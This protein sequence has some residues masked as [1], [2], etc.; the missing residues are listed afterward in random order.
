VSRRYV[1][2]VPKSVGKGRV[3]MH[4]HVIHGP[5]WPTGVNEFRAWTD[6]KPPEA[7]A[8][9]PCGWAGL[10]H[11]ASEGHVQAYRDNPER[12]KR[13]VKQLEKKH[14]VAWEEKDLSSGAHKWG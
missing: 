1:S 7:F 8:P 3:L 14:A 4:N 12:Y 9:C 10:S 13:G 2:G 5:N 6:D 11:Y